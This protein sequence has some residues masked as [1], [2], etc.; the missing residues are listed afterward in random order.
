ML[1]MLNTLYTV[2][3][4]VEKTARHLTVLILIIGVKGMIQDLGVTSLYHTINSCNSQPPQFV[5]LWGD[6]IPYRVD[7]SPS[8]QL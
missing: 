5:Q 2:D 7:L 3:S 6:S 1:H 8:I 4:R